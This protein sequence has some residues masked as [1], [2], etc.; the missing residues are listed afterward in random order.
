[1][2]DIRT[3]HPGIVRDLLG[4]AGFTCGA[5]PRVLEGRDPDWT[6][7]VDG[8]RLSGDLYI[9]AADD[10]IL[11]TGVLLALLAVLAAVAIC[12]LAAIVWMRRRQSGQ[13]YEK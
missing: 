7:V 9:H 11:P 10:P 3:E 4:E 2:P 8:E 1:M 12:Q 5:Q 6:C 13:E